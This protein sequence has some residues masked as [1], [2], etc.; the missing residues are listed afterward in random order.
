VSSIATLLGI[1]G[2][3]FIAGAGAAAIFGRP[4]KTHRPPGLLFH[5]IIPSEKAFTPLSTISQGRF[6]SVITALKSAGFSA[7]LVRDAEQCTDLERVKTPN[8]AMLLTFDDGCRSFYTTALP[9]LENAGF[10]VT[11]FPVAGYLGS[12]SS[13]DVL[14]AFQHL[15]VKEIREIS[16]LG[17]EIGSHTLTHPS[18]TFLNDADLHKELHDSKSLLE[19][20]TGNAVSSLSF[21]FGCWNRRVWDS[22]REAGFTKATLYRGRR[23]SDSSL[24]PVAGVYRFDSPASIIAR[25]KPRGPFSLSVA[26]ARMMS[27]FAKGS[28]AWKFRKNYRI[29]G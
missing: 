13:W 4:V 23:P 14:P 27:H 5:S 18:L 26:C 1:G 19:D 25:I 24:F 28:P 12:L 7:Q 9:I 11:L 15:S 17:H 21:P 6:A 3:P 10:K 8:P 16:D 22:A 20:I 29:V 2:A